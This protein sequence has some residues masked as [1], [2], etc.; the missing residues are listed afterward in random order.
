MSESPLER[1]RVVLVRPQK[2]GNVG[3]TARVMRNMGL[4][5]L[6]LVAPQADCHD[7]EAQQLSTHGQKI[8]DG[9]RIVSEFDQ[10]VADCV[11]VAGTSARTGGLFRRQSAGTIKEIMPRFAANLSTGPI[12]L[13]FGPERTGLTNDE[14]AR[15]H[16]LMHIPTD[17]GYAALNLAQA[18]AITLYELRC[19][20]LQPA[21]SPQASP[22]ACGINPPAPY[23]SQEHMFAQLQHALEQIHFLYGPKADSLMHALRH[24]I[25]RSQPSEMEIDVLHGLARQ[26]KWFA[27]N[28]PAGESASMR[29]PPR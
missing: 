21:V 12:A 3:S 26:I 14:V 20:Y 25:A 4:A 8:L 1:C 23:S 18:V 2:A 9:A 29:D 22:R 11:M 16:Y 5:D 10:A 28:K 27:N 6:V 24:L 7:R 17:S 13:V 19:C 15:C